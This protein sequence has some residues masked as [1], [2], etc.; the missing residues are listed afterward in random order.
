[1]ASDWVRAIQEIGG[2]FTDPA[3]AGF[4]VVERKGLGHPDTLADHLADEFIR[5]YAAHSM[6]VLGTVPNVCVDKTT[7]IGALA[8]LRPGGYEMDC[9]GR[10]LLIGKITKRVGRVELPIEELF[11]ASVVS[12]LEQAG[13]AGLVEHLTLEVINNDRLTD[14]HAREMY[15][16]PSVDLIRPADPRRW[17]SADT[18]CLGVEGPLTPLERLVIEVERMLTG[19]FRERNPEFGTDVKVFAA[20]RNREVD[21]TLC[22]PVKA[23][24]VPTRAA[25]FAA[26]D[27]VRSAVG[28]IADGYAEHFDVGCHVNTKDVTGSAYLTAFGSSL[29]K[30]DQGAVG[31][32]NG[33]LGVSSS[34]RRGIA[35]AVAGKNPFHHPAK[36]YTEICRAALAEIAKDSRVPV[37]I[38]VTCRNGEPL[39]SPAAVVVQ[40]DVAPATRPAFRNLVLDTVAGCGDRLLTRLP[41]T[42][43]EL[44]LRDPVAQFRGE[45]SRLLSASG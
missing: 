17:E 20:R 15:R 22:V 13:L 1:M 38:A 36:V 4:E 2:G 28:E 43:T 45:G 23:R 32:G 16:P 8:T 24:E 25:Y 31:R 44:A 30:G 40:L 21:V 41:E 11:R 37:R 34:E 5:R 27:K 33:P 18:T 39:A 12:V 3:S 29:D 9:R 10:A 19:P 42:S 6:D 7:L 14:D 35:E 26:V